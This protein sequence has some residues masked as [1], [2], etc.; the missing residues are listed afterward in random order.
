MLCY[1]NHIEYPS[2]RFLPLMQDWVAVA[3]GY[4]GLAPLN[5]GKLLEGS[6]APLQE[7]SSRPSA[8]HAHWIIKSHTQVNQYSFCGWNFLILRNWC[9]CYH[10]PNMCSFFYNSI[11]QLFIKHLMWLTDFETY[12]KTQD[13][14]TPCAAWSPAPA[15]ASGCQGCCPRQTGLGQTSSALNNTHIDWGTWNKTGK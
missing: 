8:I 9:D 7:F 3:A 4:A 13:F 11:L 2:I 14:N 10:L 15:P 5:P 1:S 6:P 12:K